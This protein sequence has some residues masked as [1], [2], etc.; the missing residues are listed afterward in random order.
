M[1]ERP[2]QCFPK[3]D[4]LPVVA[5]MKTRRFEERLV[6]F[7]ARQRPGDIAPLWG[8][9]RRSRYLLRTVA[10]PL[11]GDTTVWP[12]VFGDGVS[13]ED[14]SRLALRY[15]PPPRWRGRNQELWDDIDQ[16]RSEVN[17][18]DVQQV[19]LVAITWVS[20]DGSSRR[21]PTGAP[22]IEDEVPPRLGAKWNKVGFDV[23][24][25]FLTSGLS[26]CGYNEA[27]QREAYRRRWRTRLN[28]Y[29]LFD[30]PSDAAEFAAASDE[31]V[32]EH[33]PFLVYCIRVADP[34]GQIRA[35]RPVAPTRSRHG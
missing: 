13:A 26:N 6:G 9:D 8:T 17:R 29:H 32:P 35:R 3:T 11:S 16:M 5:P 2:G 21:S 34:L 22:Y 19:P 12:S 25:P 4:T 23:A 33:A 31:R 24:D 10:F 14:L 27:K 7:D 1:S 18:L 30:D 28:E 20:A 15:V